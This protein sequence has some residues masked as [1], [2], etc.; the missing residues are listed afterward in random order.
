MPILPAC[1]IFALGVMVGVVLGL[2]LAT[3]RWFASQM[4]RIAEYDRRL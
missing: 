1:L 3:W 4:R 2:R